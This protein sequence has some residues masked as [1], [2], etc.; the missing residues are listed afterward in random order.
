M[1][2]SVEMSRRS[3][4]ARTVFITPAL[5]MGPTLL[6]RNEIL[7]A[8]PGA[9]NRPKDPQNLTEHER[10]HVP[11]LGLPPIAEDGAVVPAYVEMSHPMEP[12]HYIKNVEILFYTDPIVS[13]GTFHFTPINGM[14]YLSTQ[15]R[16]GES[17]KV[18]CIAECNQHGRWVGAAEVKVTVG[19]C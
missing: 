7:A 8:L 1:A 12:D 3:F 15:I 11:Q 19:G 6:S 10:L 13:K 18:I 2:R 5:V 17:G 14:A 9:L 16:L 4:L